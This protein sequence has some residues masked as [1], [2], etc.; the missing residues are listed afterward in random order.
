MRCSFIRWKGCIVIHAHTISETHIC[1]S[2]ATSCCAIEQYACASIPACMHAMIPA[3]KHE[4][5][6]SLSA[7]T[8]KVVGISIAVGDCLHSLHYPKGAHMELSERPFTIM[9]AS[10]I[11]Q[12]R[13]IQ[14]SGSSTI[15]KRSKRPGSNQLE[16]NCAVKSAKFLQGWCL[17]HQ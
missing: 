9:Q 7:T 11:P 14:V 17:G 16:I 3:A 2:T 15:P 6:I 8:Q 12:E 5:P 13:T 10:L 1:C 4:V